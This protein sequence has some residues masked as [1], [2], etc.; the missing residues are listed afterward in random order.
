MSAEIGAIS[1]VNV[2]TPLL[3]ENHISLKQSTS[4][5]SEPRD[6]GNFHKSAHFLQQI[7]VFVL[8]MVTSIP[9]LLVGCTLGFPSAAIID[10]HDDE[11]RPDYRLNNLLSDVF[12]VSFKL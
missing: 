3:A 5:Q 10:L 7:R 4:I 12:G 1:Q 6:N 11:K 9:A 2:N 8:I